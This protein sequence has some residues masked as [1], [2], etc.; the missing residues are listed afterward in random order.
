MQDA[1]QIGPIDIESAPGSFE[2]KAASLSKKL[3]VWIEDRKTDLARVLGNVIDG[4]STPDE[5]RVLI[6]NAVEFDLYSWF[7]RLRLKRSTIERAKET[8]AEALISLAM[9]ERGK[10]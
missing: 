1:L 5:A 8:A 7:R 10:K 4:R 3:N 2:G 9:K 6:E